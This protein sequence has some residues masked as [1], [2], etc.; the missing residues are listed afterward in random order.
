VLRTHPLAIVG[1]HLYDNMH[2]EPPILA[3]GSP[4]LERQ[5][6][7]WMRSRLASRARR[8]I[9]LTDLRRLALAGASAS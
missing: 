5:R 9:A 6:V 4:V 1:E 8:D 3:S 7:E 2:F